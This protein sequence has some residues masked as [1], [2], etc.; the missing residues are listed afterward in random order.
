MVLGMAR[1]RKH[2]KTGVYELRLRVP[3][4]LQPLVGKREEKKSLKTKDP[5]VARVRHAIEIALVKDR[6]KNLEQGT[7]S[8]T[9]KQ[10]QAYAGEI[11]RAITKDRED[12]PGHAGL[13][14]VHVADLK[15]LR[16]RERQGNAY[17]ELMLNEPAADEV[18]EFLE[19]RGLILDPDSYS[20]LLTATRDALLQAHELI[21]KRA[22]GD[23]RPDPHADRFPELPSARPDYKKL[24]EDYRKARK[25]SNG[26]VKRWF[27]I[28]EKMVAFV[29][30]P[31][32]S[33]VTEEQL[34]EWRDHLLEGGLK[35]R[36]VKEGYIA[37]AKAFFAWAKRAKKLRNDPAREIHVEVPKEKQLRSHDLTDEEAQTILSASLAPFSSL[38]SEEHAAARRWVPWICAYTGARVNEITQMRPKDIFQEDGIW[39]M[40]I[41]PEAGTQKTKT[42]RT[43]PVHPHLIEDDFLEFVRTCK[44]ERLFY[45]VERQ[46]PGTSGQNPTSARMGQKLAEWVRGLGVDDP[47]VDPNHGWRHRFKTIGRTAGIQ[48]MILDAIQGHA[49]T[50]ESRKYGRVKPSVMLEALEA[51]PRYHVTPAAT[52][53]RR[54]REVRTKAQN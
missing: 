31:D 17:A 36:T 2:P 6:W 24:F 30:T 42:A 3:R 40:E 45:S 12:N 22:E 7:Q 27:P 21:L 1:P 4:R 38:I 5:E 34:G 46:K 14:R 33:R 50:N 49:P 15:R 29:G 26:S 35:P 52:V 25:L 16:V 37:F 18:D 53:D 23:Y 47:N 54:R 32:M 44:R 8:L 9:Q 48:E 19:Q 39:V 51:M 28:L 43:V 41:T 11:Y 10:A 13:Q 20:L